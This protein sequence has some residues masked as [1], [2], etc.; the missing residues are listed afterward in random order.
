MANHTTGAQRR[1]AG[2]EKIF[3]DARLLKHVQFVQTIAR[4]TTYN[5]D[6]SDVLE[7]A[8]STLNRLIDD[9]REMVG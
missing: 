1:N 8:V 7:D 9:A 4:M 2:M 6:S 3:E 5:L